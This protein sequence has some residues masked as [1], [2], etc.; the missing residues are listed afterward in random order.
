VFIQV[1]LLLLGKP[2]LSLNTQE[3]TVVFQTYFDDKHLGAPMYDESAQILSSSLEADSVVECGDCDCACPDASFTA[4]F[5]C[6]DLSKL[7]TAPLGHFTIPLREGFNLVHSPFSASG[8]SVLKLKAFERFKLFCVQ[9]RLLADDLDKQLAANNLIVP[10]GEQL[11]FESGNQST[12]TAWL[13][14]TNACNLDCPYCYVRK[15]SARMTEEIGSLS[16]SKLVLDAQ[17]GDFKRLKL[18]TQV[19]KLLYIINLSS[20]YMRKRYY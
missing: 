12:L 6:F 1:S 20:T 17:K 10:L 7:F 13:H 8:T 16:I 5:G 14:V 4:K 15:S 2:L 11:G 18:N 9:P 19:E 3:Q